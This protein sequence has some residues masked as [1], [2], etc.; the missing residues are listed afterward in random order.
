MCVA[1]LASACTFHVGT[2][3]FGYHDE[4]AIRLV[5]IALDDGVRRWSTSLS[6]TAHDDVITTGAVVI[7]REGDVVF[8]TVFNE[9]LRVGNQVVRA[10]GDLDCVV[11]KLA[12]GSGTVMWMRHW[13]GSDRSIDHCRGIAVDR[14]GDVVV[15][16]YFP[17]F[18]RTARFDIGTGPMT[19]AGSN[20]IFVAKLAGEDGH[21]KWVRQLGGVG[22]D[23]ARVVAIDRAGS[24]VLGGS[25]GGEVEHSAG[26]MRVGATVLSTVGGFDGFVAK[27]DRDGKPLWARALG[28]DGFDYVADLVLDRRGNIFVA[29]EIAEA[30]TLRTT[31]AR[32]SPN[33]AMTWQH[34]VE[35]GPTV[36]RAV[37]LDAKGNVRLDLVRLPGGAQRVTL[38]A[39]G[40]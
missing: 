7:T 30:G 32:V 40:R 6:T 5:T 31:A 28:R 36:P 8:T 26:T 39:R 16:G 20:D 21:T 24:I 11:G 1:V 37:S 33:G 14:S 38:S 27:L 2:A 13:P 12:G 15:V 4:G 9:Q 19:S 18:D 3:K 29:A 17:G 22:N 25:F 34:D 35:L 10:T 23:Q